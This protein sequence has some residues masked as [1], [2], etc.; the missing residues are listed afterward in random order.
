MRRE[1]TLGERASRLKVPPALFED[2]TTLPASLDH[3]KAQAASP[4]P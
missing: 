1:S 3:L 4:H 2:T